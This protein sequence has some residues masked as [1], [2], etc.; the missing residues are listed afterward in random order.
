MTTGDTELQKQPF[1]GVLTKRCSKE[2][3][4]AYRRTPMT[5]CDFNKVALQR[6]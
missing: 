5:K 1:I 2:M 4:Q 6:Y 3:Q